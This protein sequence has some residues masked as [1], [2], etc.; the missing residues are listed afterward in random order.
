MLLNKSFGGIGGT[1]KTSS[2]GASPLFASKSNEMD[3]VKRLCS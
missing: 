3:F 1:E 2:S